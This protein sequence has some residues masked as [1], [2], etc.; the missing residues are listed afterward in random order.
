MRD[1]DPDVIDDFYVYIHKTTDSN[2]VFY[3]GKGRGD[4]AY[5]LTGRNRYWKE[6]IESLNGK[7]T[8]EIV[9][10]DLLEH[11]AHILENKLILEYGK[12]SDGT[13]SLVNWTDGGEGGFYFE[14]GR[15]SQTTD[16]YEEFSDFRT[17]NPGERKDLAAMIFGHIQDWRDELE[18]IYGKACDADDFYALETEIMM[19]WDLTNEFAR[20]RSSCKSFSYDLL[21]FKEQIEY[22]IEDEEYANS[23]GIALASRIIKTFPLLHKGIQSTKQ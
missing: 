9:E 3:V 6:K 2:E 19:A 1:N 18:R 11:E 14:I 16:D 10:K 5:A 22:F 8:I 21:N 15:D 12:V 4:R 17:L 20:K 7:Y 13:G 23:P